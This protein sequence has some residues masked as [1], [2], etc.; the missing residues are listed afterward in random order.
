MT[1][2]LIFVFTGTNGAGRKTTAHRIGKELGMEHVLS[3][4]TRLPR[5]KEYPDKDYHFVSPVN[6][7]KM[8]EEQQFVET[9]WIDNVRYGVRL[10]E[11][12]RQLRSGK[13]VY[14]ILNSE[15]ASVFKQ[16][17]KEQVVRIFL[18]VSKQTML[19]RLESKGRPHEVIEQYARLYPEEVGYRRQ[20]EH[21]IENVNLN[22]TLEKIREAIL[23]HL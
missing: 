4:T 6:F 10:Q 16:L 17:Y 7:E 20:C 14:L 9:V 8:V 3:T 22:R 15:G 21:V 19:E 23:S 12:N 13:H 18:Y 2:P 5:E 1:R 11:L